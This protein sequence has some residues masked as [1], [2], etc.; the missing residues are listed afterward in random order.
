MAVDITHW[1]DREIDPT[2]EPWYRFGR[3]IDAVE[4]YGKLKPDA[5]WLD[6]GCQ[7]GE[8]LCAARKRFSIKAHGIDDFPQENAVEVYKRFSKNTIDPNVVYDGDWTYHDRRLHKTGIA[9][10]EKFDNSSP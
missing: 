2:I 8:F 3:V 5:R 10:D 6:L 7:W 9:L 1:A 4:K